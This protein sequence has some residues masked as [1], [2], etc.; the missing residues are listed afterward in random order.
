MDAESLNNQLFLWYT[1]I[2]PQKPRN[3]NYKSRSVISIVRF[4]T[5][6]Y[7]NNFK[8]PVFAQEISFE[9]NIIG[10]SKCNQLALKYSFERLTIKENNW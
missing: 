7:G 10:Q 9:N 5:R 8:V 6:I 1:R 2:E 3:R 4:M